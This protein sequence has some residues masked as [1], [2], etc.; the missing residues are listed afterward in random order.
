MTKSA[1]HCCNA[2]TAGDSARK[3]P[4]GPDESSGGFFYLFLSSMISFSENASG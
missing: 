2:Y 3:N 1:D 4:P